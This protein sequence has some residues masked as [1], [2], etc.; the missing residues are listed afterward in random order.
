MHKIKKILIL[1]PVLTAFITIMCAAAEN[2]SKVNDL[3]ENTKKLDKKSVT[4]EAE[5]IGEPMNRGANTW[6]NVNDTTNAIGIWMDSKTAEQIKNFGD[7]K[8]KGDILRITGIFYSACTEHGGDVDIHCT[9]L[10][11]V[12][13]G[14]T[15]EKS[16]P[17][18]KLIAGFTLLVPVAAAAF[19]YIKIKNRIGS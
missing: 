3:I 11:I 18:A 17:V 6:I 9:S 13:K 2:I 19:I 5:A 7:Y 15:Y 14:Y 4:I 12:K 16:I 1:I 10:S 8:H